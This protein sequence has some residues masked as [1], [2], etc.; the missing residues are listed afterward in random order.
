MRTKITLIAAIVLLTIGQA[1]AGNLPDPQKTPGDAL[2]KVPDKK[3]ASCISQK[4]GTTVSVGDP[5]TLE[6]LCT[7]GYT[8]CVRNVPS[9]TKRRSIKVTA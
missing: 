5:V 3:A 8:Q 7:S 4:M 2:T 6:I 1:L 9:K